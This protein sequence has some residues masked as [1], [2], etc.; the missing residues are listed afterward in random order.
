MI[1][2]SKVFSGW[3]LLPKGN[4]DVPVTPGC[5]VLE[6]GAF[7][8][9][10]TSGVLDA[11]LEEGILF[12]DVVGVSA[13]AMNGFNYASGQIGRAARINLRYRHDGRYIGPKTLLSDKGVIGFD[14]VMNEVEEDE[15]FDWD[16]F[17][18]QDRHFWAVA[19][20]VNTGKPRFFSK[21]ESIV[22]AVQASASMPFVSA[23]VMIDDVP[24]LDGGCSNKIPFQWAVDKGYPKILVVKTRDF[25][26]RKGDD[27]SLQKDMI[28]KFYHNHPE[29]A[30]VLADSNAEYD[31]QCDEIERLHRR[32][33]LYAVAPSK[34]VDISRLEGD[35]E[36]LGA[37]Y[38]LGYTDARRQ[39]EEIKAYLK[40]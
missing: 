33:K 14:F 12:S 4:A 36:K 7:R 19:T 9:V 34:P 25:S 22:K 31:K 35:M 6:G 5:L 8:G 15:P 3:A 1:P 20:D 21:D 39:M 26:F 30:Q 37:L 29:F 32:K 16:A 24:Y 2:N 17:N 13:G 40:A 28:M 38:Y 27:S 23:P 18:R 10:Y 11:L